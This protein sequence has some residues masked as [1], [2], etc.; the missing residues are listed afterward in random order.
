[1]VVGPEIEAKVF[2]S[3]MVKLLH[4]VT[5]VAAMTVK[6]AISAKFNAQIRSDLARTNAPRSGDTKEQGIPKCG[7]E[8]RRVVTFE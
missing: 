1:M 2:G 5:R 8:R 4:P 6:A 3:V 7:N